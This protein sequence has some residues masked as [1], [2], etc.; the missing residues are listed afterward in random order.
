VCTNTVVVNDAGL[1]AAIAGLPSLSNK[2]RN[3][4]GEVCVESSSNL[5]TISC[6]HAGGA[7][8]NLYRVPLI[9]I[10]VIVYGPLYPSDGVLFCVVAERPAAH[11]FNNSATLPLAGTRISR[12][13]VLWIS[14]AAK[15]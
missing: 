1:F 10:A 7:R 13:R 12:P 8:S 9:V 4:G 11:I 6:S 15:L 5:A 3:S 2:D 14:E